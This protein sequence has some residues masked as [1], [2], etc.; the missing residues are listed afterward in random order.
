M[1]IVRHSHAKDFLTTRTVSVVN[2]LTNKECDESLRRKAF[3]KTLTHLKENAILSKLLVD[4]SHAIRAVLLF[5][6]GENVI[7]AA[8]RIQQPWTFYKT[9]ATY[10]TLQ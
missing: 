7:S 6:S 8:I 9:E 2:N 5:V 10:S 4:A 1:N 3:S